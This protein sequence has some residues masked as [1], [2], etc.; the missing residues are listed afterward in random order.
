M[1]FAQTGEIPPGANPIKP[2]EHQRTP[3]KRTMSMGGSAGRLTAANSLAST[4]GAGAS[5]TGSITAALSAANTSA[6]P[7]APAAK[8]AARSRSPTRAGRP[9][10]G[11]SSTAALGAQRSSSTMADSSQ[12]Q[13]S[14]SST[15]ST[16]PT[17][18]FN[19]SR[20][21]STTSASTSS[22]VSALDGSVEVWTDGSCLGNG[23]ASAR[24]GYAVYFG[25]EDPRWAFRF[26]DAWSDAH[27][28][29]RNESGRVPGSQTNNRG[30][31]LV[32]LEVDRFDNDVNR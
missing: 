13:H 21:S 4:S 11:A 22:A 5:K 6:R 7:S 10:A 1:S 3:A 27:S 28:E 17:L 24:A 12:R 23:K 25:P 16:A 19:Q 30:E 9:T 29:D 31:L 18:G 20:S 26:V 8:A 15:A 32:S 2:G 14:M